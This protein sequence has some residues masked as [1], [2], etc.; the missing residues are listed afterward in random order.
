MQTHRV[1]CAISSPAPNVGKVEHLQVEQLAEWR[2]S[3]RAH[4]LL[5]VR[6]AGEIAI[7]AL[8]GALHVP[9]NEIPARLSQ[10][11]READ[12]AVLCHV[13]ARSFAVAKYLASNGYERVYN[14]TGGID[15]YAELVDS[16]IPRYG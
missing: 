11:P 1:L 4:V 5:D 6:E 2:R 9:M 3:G 14:V 10:I 12:V 15:R 8:D 13:G 16:S 7:A